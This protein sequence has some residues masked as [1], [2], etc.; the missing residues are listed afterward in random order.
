MEIRFLPLSKFQQSQASESSRSLGSVRARH[1]IGDAMTFGTD[2]V[3][4]EG[5]EVVRAQVMLTA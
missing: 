2:D 1:G 3:L 5:D 4:C